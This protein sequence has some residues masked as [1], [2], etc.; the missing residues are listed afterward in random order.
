MPFSVIIVGTGI[1]GLGAATALAKK[2]HKVTVVEATS[3]LRPIGGC[4][5]LQAN[6]NRVLHSL[7]VYESLIPF[8]SP[9]PHGPSTRRYDT[10]EFLAQTSAEAHENEY[11]YP[12]WPVHRANLQHVLFEAAMKQGVVLKLG[13]LVTAVEEDNL[14]L[15][16]VI[17]GQDRMYADVIVGA[18]GKSTKK[19]VLESDELTPAGIH[20]TVRRNI[21]PD[22][23]CVR[24]SGID[25][26]RA[27]IP[28]AAIRSDPTTSMFLDHIS[29]WCGP[30]SSIAAMAVRLGDEWV[31]GV[32]CCH[33]R[34]D[35]V[36]ETPHRTQD[37]ERFKAHFKDYHPAILQMLSYV[38]EANV[39]RLKEATP[40]TWI[41]TSG[42][43]ILI[44][45]A[46]HG[47]LPWVGQGGGMALEDAVCLAVCL[48]RAKDVKDIP[49]ALKVFQD[50]RQPRCKKVQEWS[51]TKGQRARLTGGSNQQER[52]SK[53]VKANAWIKADPWDKVHIDELPEF[54][55]PNWKAWLSGHNAVDYVKTA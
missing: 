44:G 55:A 24:D 35:V 7:G 28:A 41:G 16:V 22:S 43:V 21:V 47:S 29:L 53:I 12:L 20:S 33:E 51:A 15:S 10:G 6:A 42:R 3:E 30:S 46:A 52:D 45:D 38:T 4:I 36:S 34:D 11:G 9:I 49:A 27:N 37:I 25:I 2:G 31:L 1:A 14:E 19:A 8:C 40:P 23:A 26:T 18:D 48:E 32:D 54:E 17:N 5:V 13:C 39:W 50:I